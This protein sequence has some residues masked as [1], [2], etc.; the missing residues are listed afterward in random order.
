MVQYEF[1][2]R[3][4][5]CNFYTACIDRPNLLKNTSI[6]CMKC[7]TAVAYILFTTSQ[8]E[9][10]FLR[11]LFYI[12][13]LNNEINTNLVHCEVHQTVLLLCIMML[14]YQYFHGALLLFPLFL[15]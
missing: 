9:L 12:M 1:S 13:F 5:I 14:L 7:V 2:E 4:H 6:I 11:I 15:P 10:D 8:F 3:M